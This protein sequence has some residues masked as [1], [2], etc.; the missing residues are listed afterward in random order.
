MAFLHL[1]GILIVSTLALYK[2]YTWKVPEPCC[3]FAHSAADWYAEARILLISSRERCWLAVSAHVWL[4]LQQHADC[5][6]VVVVFHPAASACT[7][8]AEWH[9][10]DFTVGNVAGAGRV[11]VLEYV[12]IRKQTM[13]LCPLL[14]TGWHTP[15]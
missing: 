14:P 13:G 6:P 2:R 5:D 9:A 11:P 8:P 7:H 1:T 3:I 4:P 15:G 10:L 12:F